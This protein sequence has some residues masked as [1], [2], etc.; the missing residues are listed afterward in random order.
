MIKFFTV[1]H[2][3]PQLKGIA[4]AYQDLA[5]EIIM[6]VPAGEQ[7][8]IALQKLLESKDATIRAIIEKRL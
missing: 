3:P 6:R 1:D 2:L 7:R 4:S 8:K 5:E